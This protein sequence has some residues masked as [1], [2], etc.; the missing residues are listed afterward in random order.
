MKG[1]WLVSEVNVNGGAL[2]QLGQLL[3]EFETNGR[4]LIYMMDNGLMKGE[5]Y[6]GDALDYEVFGEWDLKTHDYIYMKIDEYIDGTFLLRSNG[7][8]EFTLY[9]DSNNIA[10]YDRN[11]HNGT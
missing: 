7:K 9:C 5:Y 4:Y 2:N 1:E 11:N 3:P 6:I 8:Q 10:F